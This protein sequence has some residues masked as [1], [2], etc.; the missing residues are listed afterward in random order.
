MNQTLNTALDLVKT[1]KVQ[2]F[3]RSVKK[4]IN[5]FEGDMSSE[6]NFNGYNNPVTYQQHLESFY[7]ACKQEIAQEISHGL[8][9]MEDLKRQFDLAKFEVREFR[10]RYFPK[11][12]NE[13]LFQRI[14]FVKSPR[15]DH[16]SDD[17]IKKNSQ[18]FPGSV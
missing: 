18:L 1:A 6:I 11:N 9:Q 16:I 14:E 2:V 8:N 5:L 13:A 17:G 10:Q 12:D 15:I 3:P 7:L 4:Q